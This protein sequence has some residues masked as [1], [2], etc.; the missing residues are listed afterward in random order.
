[1]IWKLEVGFDPPHRPTAMLQI[2]EPGSRAP[3]WES[4]FRMYDLDGSGAILYGNYSSMGST[5]RLSTIFGIT[6]SQY[7]RQKNTLSMTRQEVT[8]EAHFTSNRIQDIGNSPC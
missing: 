5:T 8:H 2:P 3:Y 1:M 7:P 4:N 6:I